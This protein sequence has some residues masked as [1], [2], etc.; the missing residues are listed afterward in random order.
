[1]EAENIKHII[2]W[3]EVLLRVILHAVRFILNYHW[4]ALGGALLYKINCYKAIL[5]IAL[6]NMIWLKTQ[7]VLQM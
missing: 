7:G 6:T 4:S 2:K 5:N 1:M 3:I